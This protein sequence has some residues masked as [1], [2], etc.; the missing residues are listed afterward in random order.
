MMNKRADPPILLKER[1]L[2]AVVV[3]GANLVLR[4][5]DATSRREHR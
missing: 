1:L 4:V 2:L 3:V 5:V